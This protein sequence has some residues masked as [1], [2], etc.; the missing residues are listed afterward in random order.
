[1]IRHCSAALPCLA[2]LFLMLSQV[3]HAQTAQPAAVEGVLKLPK[4][5]PT[6]VVS[7]RYEV[8][9]HNGTLATNPPLGVV[10]LEGNFP[11]PTEP[12]TTELIQEG[13][14]F[15]PSLLPVRKGTRNV[16]SF[17]PTKRFDLG[18]YRPGD[19]PVPSQEFDK[20]GLVTLRCEIHQHMRGLILVLD[21]P[22]F[23]ITD[24][25]GH[26]RMEGLPPGHYLL[27]AWLNS[28]TTLELPIDLIAGQ[29]FHAEFP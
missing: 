5:K 14:A 26:F 3:G 18:R 2:V 11:E 9:N 7:Q 27:K 6:P 20:P 19:K 10:Y 12:V 4:A 25:L 28:K 13:L 24:S 8:V 21:T 17:S 1:M 29:T 22:Y 15:I 23:V 16:F